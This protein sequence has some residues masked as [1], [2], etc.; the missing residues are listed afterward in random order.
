LAST[1][2]APSYGRI[3]DLYGRRTTYLVVL[4]LFL[5]GSALCGASVNMEMLIACRAIQG[6]GGG[7][8]MGKTNH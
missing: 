2:F 4:I 5:T 3:S 1:A 6:I 7:G 8:L